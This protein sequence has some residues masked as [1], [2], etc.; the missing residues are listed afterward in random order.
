MTRVYILEQREPW[1]SSDHE[2]V[3]SSLELATEH[4]LA[5]KYV[6]SLDFLVLACAPVDCSAIADDEVYEWGWCVHEQ[7]FVARPTRAQE[8][9]ERLVTHPPREVSEEDLPPQH[10]NCNANVVPH[11][12][13]ETRQ[14]IERV[15]GLS[16]T[17]A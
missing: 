4:V 1:E 10:V 3:F 12:E 16:T 14:C 9:A 15:F 17:E 2:G 13:E 8:R 11:T 5:S 7:A 6:R